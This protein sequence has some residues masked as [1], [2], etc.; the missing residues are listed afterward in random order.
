[1]PADL[2]AAELEDLLYLAILAPTIKHRRWEYTQVERACRQAKAAARQLSP[3]SVSQLLQ[4]AA[5]VGAD[6]AIKDLR[7]NVPAAEVVAPTLLGN[8]LLLAIESGVGAAATVEALL[9]RHFN[10]WHLAPP[11]QHLDASVFCH[12]VH[13]SMELEQ[14]QAAMLIQGAPSPTA[15]QLD[16][17][18]ILKL[19]VVMIRAADE[20]DNVSELCELEGAQQFDQQTL[21]HLMEVAEE[22]WGSEWVGWAEEVRWV[23]EWVGSESAEQGEGCG[24][25]GVIDA[26]DDARSSTSHHSSASCSSSSSDDDGI[27]GNSQ[28]IAG[29][30]STGGGA[31]HCSRNVDDGS[32]YKSKSS[33]SSA[34]S[35]S[36]L[37]S[38]ELAD[39]GRGR[40]SSSSCDAARLGELSSRIG[41]DFDDVAGS[42][43][44]EQGLVQGTVA[45][46]IR[47]LHKF[48]E[49][50]REKKEGTPS[51]HAT[52]VTEELWESADID[53]S[54]EYYE[55][56]ASD[57]P[58]YTLGPAR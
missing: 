52:T 12:L 38:S 20:P 36:G 6:A 27:R 2:P 23:S 30:N 16:A 31:C 9:W 55:E 11:L 54:E 47:D 33:S 35:G 22:V 21:E 17:A 50:R 25:D 1:M 48:A 28:G 49:W 18:A 58:Q 26:A 41:G 3:D 15:A 14:H 34:S 53:E 39:N 19:L 10:H 44:C 5:L 24:S 32:S 46:S 37:D 56:L 8:L 13:H 43:G 42:Q 45:F 29:G 57:W 51:S 4:H 7:S 40:I